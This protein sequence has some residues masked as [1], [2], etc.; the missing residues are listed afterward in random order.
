VQSVVRRKFARLEFYRRREVRHSRAAKIIQTKWRSLY[1]RMAYQLSLC[2][3]VIAQTVVRRKL[4]RL[5]F[6]RRREV[7]VA[8]M[9]QTKWRSTDAL[10]S[11]ELYLMLAVEIQTFARRRLVVFHAPF[12]LSSRQGSSKDSSSLEVIRCLNYRK[13]KAATKIQAAWRSFDG[14]MNFLHLLADVIIIQGVAKA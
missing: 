11:Y 8:T 6:H 3:I 4:A 14:T 2:D 5:E 12:P 1:A 9:I 10:I 13:C 7:Q